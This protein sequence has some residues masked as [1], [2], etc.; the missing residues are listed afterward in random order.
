MANRG[1]FSW[2]RLLGISAAKS[3]V[4]RKVGFPLFGGAGSRQRWLGRKLGMK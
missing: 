4:S 2:S 3:R 1:G